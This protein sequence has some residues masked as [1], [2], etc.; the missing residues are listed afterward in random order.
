[1]SFQRTLSLVWVA[2]VV[3]LLLGFATSGAN[4]QGLTTL[5]QE[6]KCVHSTVLRF[7]S[8]ADTLLHVRSGQVVTTSIPASTSCPLGLSPGSLGR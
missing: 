3:L 1:M 6:D 2:N 8:S 5:T 4:A 7:P